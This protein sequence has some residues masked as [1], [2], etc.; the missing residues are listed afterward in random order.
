MLTPCSIKLQIQH[1]CKKAVSHQLGFL[2]ILETRRGAAVIKIGRTLIL[3]Q[4]SLFVFV[5]T[6][7]GVNEGK[8][9][10]STV[11]IVKTGPSQ[12]KSGVDSSR[13]GP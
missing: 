1:V 3:T 2:N 6:R 10:G 11:K 8:G 13:A 9:K 5:W 7:G 12:E 4:S